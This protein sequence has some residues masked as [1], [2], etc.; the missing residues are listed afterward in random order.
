MP[1]VT[2]PHNPWIKEL[3]KAI[4]RGGQT[5]DGLVVAEG[6]HLIAEALRSKCE[7]PAVFVTEAARG[8][9]AQ[10]LD[11]VEAAKVSTVPTGLFRE[12]STTETSQGVIALVRPPQWTLEQVFGG[13]PL[14]VILDGLQD[15]GNAG[16]V[17]RAAEA[18]GATGVVALKGTVNPYNPKCVRASAGS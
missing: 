16:T 1:T 15:P 10:C 12:I 4:R 3:R 11:Q 17:L 5:D 14:V 9:M 7:I 6:P 8:P 18:F 2:S 13:T